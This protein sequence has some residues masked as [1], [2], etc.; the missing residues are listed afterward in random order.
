M[1][2]V[3][4]EFMKLSCVVCILG[5]LLFSRA[6]ARDWIKLEAEDFT[7]MSDAREATV[8]EFALGFAAQRHALRTLLARPGVKVPR[9]IM[10]LHSRSKDF[11]E[12]TSESKTDWNTQRF[13][14]SVIIDGQSATTLSLNS[15]DD[16]AFEVA[17]EFDTM[18][19][20]KRLGYALPTWMSQGTGQVFSTTRVDIKKGMVEVGRAPPSGRGLS[21]QNFLRWSRFFEVTQS[22]DEYRGRKKF[23]MYHAQSWA[24]M[25][26]ILFQD[27][28]GP[29]RF[30]ALAERLNSAR[31]MEAVLEVTGVELKQLGRSVTRHTGTRSPTVEIPFDAARV[32]TGFKISPLPDAERFAIMT[33]FAAAAGKTHLAN[34]LY[35]QAEQMLPDSPQVLESG[36]RWNLRQNDR[37]SALRFYRRAIEKGSTNPRA[38]LYSADWRLDRAGGNIDRKGDGIPIVLEP[39]KAEVDRALELDP[40]MGQ[41]YALLGRIAFVEPEPNAAHL[42]RLTAGIGPD[43]W[44]TRARYY[45]ALLLERLGRVDEAIADMRILEDHPE[46]S[47]A[48]REGA[49][50]SVAMWELRGVEIEVRSLSEAGKFQEAWKVLAEATERGGDAASLARLDEIKGRLSEYQTR[51]EQADYDR[52]LKRLQGMLKRRASEEAWTEVKALVAGATSES[53]TQG[54]R[55]LEIQIGGLVLAQRV[56][57]AT[58]EKRWADVIENAELFL[59]SQPEGHKSRTDVTESLAQARSEVGQRQD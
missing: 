52:N 6:E 27:E 50:R 33:D 57:A 35:Y 29:Q 17:M 10:I 53:L 42:D 54:Y 8:V 58:R 15:A 7:L 59:S 22:S 28:E 37:E 39:A 49:A 18:W 11:R 40:G 32:K 43:F 36:A 26:W 44:G 41:A 48:T 23:G 21:S 13:S 34:Y 31:G 2:I 25:H 51:R 4:L 3:M 38:Y 12:Y 9:S 1:V 46:S 19:A 16:R 56:R 5:L 20:L 47:S 24:L 45:R 55:R 30:I 14:S